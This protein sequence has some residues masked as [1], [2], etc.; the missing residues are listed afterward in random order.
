MSRFATAQDALISRLKATAGSSVT[1]ARGAASVTLTAWAGK[2][3]Q[4]WSPQGQ[5]PGVAV[6]WNERDYLI[7][8][9]DLVLSGSATTPQE[10]DTITETINGTPTK[11]AVTLDG[12]E[13][14]WRYSDQTRKLFRIHCKRVP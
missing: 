12:S 11:F 6:A 1:Y 2:S 8:V 7:A 3:V 14:C 5:S 4:L 10:G 9:E 13:P